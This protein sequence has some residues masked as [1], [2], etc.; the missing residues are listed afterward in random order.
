[1]LGPFLIVA[2][3]AIG[4]GQLCVCIGYAQAVLDAFRSFKVFL[5]KRNDGIFR[6]IEP[7]QIDFIDGIYFRLLLWVQLPK[8]ETEKKKEE[9]VPHKYY[10]WICGC[11][12]RAAER[13]YF[14][15][16]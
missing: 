7:L 3:V 11:S 12:R 8:T 13:L 10:N 14:K 1:M 6:D 9:C 5:K 15:K 4:K 16:L 2:L